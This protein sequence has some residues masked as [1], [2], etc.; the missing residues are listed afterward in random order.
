MEV[1]VTATS[2]PNVFNVTVAQSGSGGQ[3]PKGDPGKSAYEIAVDNGFVGTEQ[4]WLDSLE[5]PPGPAGTTDYNELDNKPTLGTAAAADVTDFATAEQGAKADSALQSVQAGDNI[6]IDNTDPN[7][8]VIS[9]TSSVSSETDWGDIGGT[10]SDQT[11]IQDALNGKATAAQGALADT[12]VQPDDIL[13]GGEPAE[14]LVTGYLEGTLYN[15]SGSVPFNRSST[16]SINGSV[17]LIAVSA[18]EWIA[19]A[20]IAASLSNTNLAVVYTSE[21]AR[22]SNMDIDALVA[23]EGGHKVQM[24]TN[25]NIAFI[26]FNLRNADLPNIHVYRG[27]D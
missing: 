21:G 13:T 16:S 17:D 20:G 5:G 10:L 15:L 9:A 6:T 18:N 7:N 1:N 2:T 23:I 3:G 4:Q 22:V 11:D 26:G 24:G 14:D 12:A 27:F 19:I 8:P 25:S